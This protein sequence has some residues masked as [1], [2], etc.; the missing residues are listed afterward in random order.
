MKNMVHINKHAVVRAE[1]PALINPIKLVLLALALVCGLSASGQ[2]STLTT[3]F[4]VGA[5]VP[6]ASPSGLASAKTISTPIASITGLKVSLK[7]S[8]TFNGDLYAYLTHSSGH[9][10]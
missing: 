1:W 2:T 7:L 6:D 10:V 4:V 5:G 9:S 8:G 3:N